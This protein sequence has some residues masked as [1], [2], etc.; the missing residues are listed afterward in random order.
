MKNIKTVALLAAFTI[1][2][3]SCAKDF[4]DTK[5]TSSVDQVTMFE[6]TENCMAALNGIHRLMYDNSG[7]TAEGGME[8]LIIWLDLLGEDMVVTN[9]T[10]QLVDV[11]Q[12]TV[13]RS[14]THSY[15]LYQFR[16][17]YSIINNANMLIENID[18]A[19]GGE[20]VKNYIKGQAHAYRAYAYFVLVQCWGGRYKAEGNN[21]QLGVVLRKKVGQ[22]N[23]P[24]ESV[25][26]VYTYINQEIDAAI[27]LLSKVSVKK[28]NKTHI[29]V[30]VARGIKARVLL[31]QGKWREAAEMAKLVV[32]KS[33]AKLQADTYTTTKMRFADQSNTEW[34]W[35]KL[36]LEEQYSGGCLFDFM[37]NKNFIYAYQSP[38]AIYNKLYDKISPTD[39]RKNVWLPEA[40][41]PNSTPRPIVSPG[42]GCIANYMSQ[43]F[44]LTNSSMKNGD[45]PWMRLPEMMLIEAE[46]YARAGEDALAAQAL[47]P[48]AVQR[49]PQYALSTNT[50][51]DLI[52]EIMIQRRVEL[53]GE[54]FRFLDLKRLD[55]PLDRG[56]KTRTELGYS[57]DSWASS[58]TLEGNSKMPTNVDP[59]AS[60]FNMYDNHHM[61]EDCRTRPAGHN[62]WQFAF[63]KK[64]TDQNPLCEQNPW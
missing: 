43:K 5:S 4:M 3:S 7:Y 28:T 40:Q 30:H 61:G 31:T 34:L 56:P 42:N 25:E 64:E 38:R 11:G 52:D 26:N 16:N 59:E 35:G 54:G 22:E 14:N 18:G 19:Q 29:D 39:V 60:N 58:L 6:T 57:D 9:N 15:L 62:D 1:L 33:G 32:D 55:M 36:G 45:V 53:W 10:A 27:D 41:D 46:G 23:L 47:Y 24:R 50:G 48:L 21:S 8:T 49:D 44:L 63:P 13:H 17:L 20:D 37:S 51:Q 2:F 12:W